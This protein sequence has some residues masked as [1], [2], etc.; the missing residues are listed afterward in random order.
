MKGNNNFQAPASPVINTTL[1]K[2]SK[3][4]TYE[5]AQLERGRLT[6]PIYNQTQSIGFTSFRNKKPTVSAYVPRAE[7]P[8]LQ[9]PLLNVNKGGSVLLD[10]IRSASGNN[11]TNIPEA[12]AVLSVAYGTLYDF[13]QYKIIENM[14]DSQYLTEIDTL[15]EIFKNVQEN[16]KAID[17]SHARI[18]TNQ[19]RA[20]IKPNREVLLLYY[21]LD[22]TNTQS[23]FSKEI[24]RYINMAVAQGNPDGIIK[25]PAGLP[26]TNDFP[27]ANYKDNLF[28]E[29]VVKLKAIKTKN[30]NKPFDL[31]ET[32]F[33]LEKTEFIKELLDFSENLIKDIKTEILNSL[34]SKYNKN[35]DIHIFHITEVEKAIRKLREKHGN[36]KEWREKAVL[37]L[38]LLGIDQMHSEIRDN[39]VISLSGMERGIA[40]A[41]Q[42]INQ[43]NSTF[44]TAKT[45]KNKQQ[46]L[47]AG[48]QLIRGLSFIPSGNGLNYGGTIMR[49]FIQGYLSS[50]AQGKDREFELPTY[51]EM[52]ENENFTSRTTRGGLIVNAPIFRRD[53]QGGRR[54]AEP[55]EYY[56]ASKTIYQKT[57]G[58]AAI[59]F[60]KSFEQ[61]KKY[62][63]TIT[64]IL[65]QKKQRLKK[66]VGNVQSVKHG[67]VKL[68]IQEII[69]IGN[70][71]ESLKELEDVMKSENFGE[72]WGE[73]RIHI[74]NIK[75]VLNELEALK[76]RRD[77]NEKTKETIQKT[78]IATRNLIRAF[79]NINDIRSQISGFVG[80]LTPM[81]GFWGYINWTY[82]DLTYFGL[83]SPLIIVKDFLDRRAEELRELGGINIENLK[84]SFSEGI[85][86]IAEYGDFADS[87]LMGAANKFGA[88]LYEIGLGG[89][90]GY[91]H[92][93]YPEMFY[94]GY[95]QEFTQMGQTFAKDLGLPESFGYM[96]SAYLL[97]SFFNPINL[98]IS[99][100]SFLIPGLGIG[101]KTTQVISTLLKGSMG[102]MKLLGSAGRAGKIGRLAVKLGD[103]VADI[104]LKYKSPILYSIKTGSVTLGLLHKNYSLLSKLYGNIGDVIDSWIVSGGDPTTILG[105]LLFSNDFIGPI[106]HRGLAMSFVPEL[107]T[108]GRFVVQTMQNNRKVGE[109]IKSMGVDQKAV[110]ALDKLIKGELEGVQVY[111]TKTGYVGQIVS[112]DETNPNIVTIRY[113]SGE[114]AL[115]EKRYKGDLVIIDPSLT[116]SVKS[117]P[118]PNAALSLLL[119]LYHRETTTNQDTPSGLVTQIFGNATGEEVLRSLQ[120]L[121][122]IEISQDT[123]R[124]KLTDKAKSIMSLIFDDSLN[125]SVIARTI[126]SVLP[127]TKSTDS[128]NVQNRNARLTRAVLKAWNQLSPELKRAFAV[129][130]KLLTILK[131]MDEINQ[132]GEGLQTI[133]EI[134]QVNQIENA[135]DLQYSV[136]ADGSDGYIFTNKP[137]TTDLSSPDVGIIEVVL[138]TDAAVKPGI[139]D[140]IKDAIESM[141]A[142][143]E[144]IPQAYRKNADGTTS[145]FF[146]GIK[147]YITTD[148]TGQRYKEETTLTDGDMK[149]LA[150]LLSR[151]IDKIKEVYKQMEADPSLH[152]KAVLETIPQIIGGG[153]A[154]KLPDR[155]QQRTPTIKLNYQ[156]QV[157]SL[158]IPAK[159]S[160][161]F[162]TS[163]E[164]PVVETRIRA[165]GVPGHT[166]TIPKELKDYIFNVG[167][168]HATD[169]IVDKI[170]K[171]LADAETTTPERAAGITHLFD[172]RY[173]NIRQFFNNLRIAAQSTDLVH[174]L[175]TFSNRINASYMI[176][177][178]SLQSIGDDEKAIDAMRQILD[179]QNPL[180]E[181]RKIVDKALSEEVHQEVEQILKSETAYKTALESLPLGFKE[182]L[183]RF[184]TIEELF[185]YL[186]DR[187]RDIRRDLGETTP[188][189]R[190]HHHLFG[191][192][193]T[194]IFLQ[195]LRASIPEITDAEIIEAAI[196]VALALPLDILAR[197]GF[198]NI[199]ID[200]RKMTEQSLKGLLEEKL[201]GPKGLKASTPEN[202]KLNT[203]IQ[204]IIQDYAE[205]EMLVWEGNPI[206]LARR[207]M[208]IF[209]LTNRPDLSDKQLL[210]IKDG[211]EA[212]ARLLID[213][214]DSPFD[215]KRDVKLVQLMLLHNKDISE[216][217]TLFSTLKQTSYFTNF[218][219]ASKSPGQRPD[220]IELTIMR[221]LTDPYNSIYLA[222]E[223]THYLHYKWALSYQREK[224]YG[225]HE[226]VS[227]S[228]RKAAKLMNLFTSE[229]TSESEY[230]LRFLSTRYNAN[231]LK[232][233]QPT[234]FDKLMPVTNYGQEMRGIFEERFLGKANLEFIRKINENIEQHGSLYRLFREPYRLAIIYDMN[235]A[236]HT[237]GKAHT[238]TMTTK[239]HL[240]TFMR[241]ID[242]TGGSF[243]EVIDETIT[244]LAHNSEIKFFGEDDEQAFDELAGAAIGASADDAVKTEIELEPHIEM[245]LTLRDLINYSATRLAGTQ[246][247]QSSFDAWK[248]RVIIEAFGRR[249][250]T[251]NKTA[252]QDIQEKIKKNPLVSHAYTN[253]S[254]LGKALMFAITDAATI[255][256]EDPEKNPIEIKT[257]ALVFK[258]PNSLAFEVKLLPKIENED[259]L[260]ETVYARS[261]EQIIRPLARSIENI[262]TLYMRIRK[263]LPERN[264]RLINDTL[265]SLINDDGSISQE[266]VGLLR[267]IVQERIA[268]PIQELRLDL[269][270]NS[271]FLQKVFPIYIVK[272]VTTKDQKTELRVFKLY[273][274]TEID[275]EKSSFIG[276]IVPLIPEN[277]QLADV[278]EE[279]KSLAYQIL[280]GYNRIFNNNTSLPPV[281]PGLRLKRK[282]DGAYLT[283]KEVVVNENGN[284]AAKLVVD[285]EGTENLVIRRTYIK[286][287]PELS[288]E[289]MPKE[290]EGVPADASTETVFSSQIVIS[291]DNQND[292]PIVLF[293][294]FSILEK[295]KHELRTQYGNY[296]GQLANDEDLINIVYATLIQGISE[297]S[298]LYIKEELDTLET[299]RTSVHFGSLD[300]V[301]QK[302]PKAEIS[303]ARMLLLLDL[304]EDAFNKLSESTPRLL[305]KDDMQTAKEQIEKRKQA[306]KIMASLIKK[307]KANFEQ[308][309]NNY[310]QVRVT[311]LMRIAANPHVI[312]KTLDA[313]IDE[314]Y[315][316]VADIKAN[317]GNS[318]FRQRTY[319]EISP[320]LREIARHPF[321]FTPEISLENRL[322]TVEFPEIV[323]LGSLLGPEASDPSVRWI[324]IPTTTARE[325]GIAISDYVLRPF[326][327][328][329]DR[330]SGDWKGDL[331]HEIENR[332]YSILEIERDYLPNLTATPNAILQF[333]M[334]AAQSIIKAIDTQTV[335]DQDFHT[336]TI[337]YLPPTATIRVI[338]AE[339]VRDGIR[340]REPIA[341][342]LYIHDSK[343]NRANKLGKHTL[344]FEKPYLELK[345]QI[346]SSGEVVLID[347]TFWSEYEIPETEQ[348]YHYLKQLGGEMD[349]LLSL[350]AKVE[351]TKKLSQSERNVIRSLWRTKKGSSPN[352]LMAILLALKPSVPLFFIPVEDSFDISSKIITLTPTDQELRLVQEAKREILQAIKQR[353]ATSR[354]IEETETIETRSL[355][356]QLFDT[357]LR[358]D[359]PLE[360]TER[361]ESLKIKEENFERLAFNVFP[362]LNQ[363][364][365]DEIGRIVNEQIR[366]SA[367]TPRSVLM[368]ML[369]GAVQTTY[370]NQLDVLKPILSSSIKDA[371]SESDRVPNTDIDSIADRYATA[372]LHALTNPLIEYSLGSDRL[373]ETVKTLRK[374]I[375]D[376]YYSSTLPQENNGGGAG[377][378]LLT[379]SQ[380]D[381]LS[382]DM[383]N[384]LLK[385]AG[386]IKSRIDEYIESNLQ[387]IEEIYTNF[388]FS[389]IR[390][391]TAVQEQQVDQETIQSQTE[392][393]DNEPLNY[394]ELQSLYKDPELQDVLEQEE[395]TSI[396]DGNV[397]LA[398]KSY[399]SPF[400]HQDR[401]MKDAGNA[402]YFAKTESAP[403]DNVRSNMSVVFGVVGSDD[404]PYKQT[405]DKYEGLIKR[406]ENGVTIFE[407]SK[408]DRM[409]RRYTN[410]PK[411][412]GYGG[413]SQT[414]ANTNQILVDQLEKLINRDDPFSIT[415]L[416]N[417]QPTN[418][419][420][421]APLTLTGVQFKGSVEAL[422]T[423]FVYGQQLVFETDAETRTSIKSKA[424]ADGITRQ[425]ALD[426][427]TVKAPT[428]F[429]SMLPGLVSSVE[430]VMTELKTYKDGDYI[431]APSIL[432]GNKSESQTENGIANGGLGYN[433]YHFLNELNIKINTA[434]SELRKKQA[435]ITSKDIELISHKTFYGI[436]K[437]ALSNEPETKEAKRLKFI[438]EN[439][440][441]AK[442]IKIKVGENRTTEKTVVLTLKD[443]ILLK[444]MAKANQTQIALD[445]SLFDLETG[446]FK[447]APLSP[448]NEDIQNK[449][450][451][452]ISNLD[453]IVILDENTSDETF[454]FLTSILLTI[455]TV[456][457]MTIFSSA[458]A[459]YSQSVSDGL[460][461]TDLTKYKRR[462]QREEE[463]KTKRDAEKLLRFKQEAVIPELSY[464]LAFKHT[465]ADP[466][467][468]NNNATL[469]N[470]NL[471]IPRDEQ[472]E[473]VYD[474][475]TAQ[476]RNHTYT[477]VTGHTNFSFVRPVSKI[478]PTKYEEPN[479]E[480][481][482]RP[483][484]GVHELEYEAQ[485]PIPLLSDAMK[486]AVVISITKL[487]DEKSKQESQTETPITTRASLIQ[488]YATRWGLIIPLQLLEN[489]NKKLLTE[490]E[491]YK[492]TE[493]ILSFS[494]TTLEKPTDA[495]SLL[496]NFNKP[497]SLIQRMSAIA[498]YWMYDIA[499]WVDRFSKRIRRRAF[500]SETI[501]N[502]IGDSEAYYTETAP[503]SQRMGPFLYATA[504]SGVSLLNW[505]AA[506]SRYSIN[507]DFGFAVMAGIIMPSVL[508]FLY[509][510]A[511]FH[512]SGLSKKFIRAANQILRRQKIMGDI[513]KNMTKAL[514]ENAQNPIKVENIKL[515]IYRVINYLSASPL[516]ENFAEMLPVEFTTNTTE[517][518]SSL[519][520]KGDIEI[521]R[522]P[523]SENQDMVSEVNNRVKRIIKNRNTIRNPILNR[524]LSLQE[525][526]EG[527]RNVYDVREQI[528]EDITYILSVAIDE[529]LAEYLGHNRI[530]ETLGETN[531]HIYN[532]LKIFKHLVFTYLMTRAMTNKY[533]VMTGNNI[534]ID[535]TN[536]TNYI[537][538]LVIAKDRD[539]NY[540]IRTDVLI[541]L[542]DTIATQ[543]TIAQQNRSNLEPQTEINEELFETTSV[544]DRRKL[545]GLLAAARFLNGFVQEPAIVTMTLLNMDFS[546]GDNVKAL[547]LSPRDV[548]YGFVRILH[549]R[550]A[551]KNNS[552]YHDREAF[553]A[554]DVALLLNRSTKETA[555]AINRHVEGPVGNLL[556]TLSAQ[557]GFYLGRVSQTPLGA[558]ISF[559]RD[560]L[561]ILSDAPAVIGNNIVNIL[562]LTNPKLFKDQGN[563]KTIFSRIA[564]EAMSAKS[565]ALL[566]LGLPMLGWM[567]DPI[568]FG[569]QNISN[570]VIPLAKT[571]W[572]SY[573]ILPALM[574]YQFRGALAMARALLPNTGLFFS[575]MR[576]AIG[577][578]VI[579]ID[580]G[581]VLKEKAKALVDV[582]KDSSGQVLV[583]LLS[584]IA[585]RHTFNPSQKETE[586]AEEIEDTLPPQQISQAMEVKGATGFYPNK[587]VELI[588]ISRD[589][590][591]KQFLILLGLI[592]PY[593]PDAV[594]KPKSFAAVTVKKK[595]VF[596]YKESEKT[597]TNIEEAI[598]VG[599]TIALKDNRATT[600]EDFLYKLAELI[601]NNNNIE[602]VVSS[603]DNQTIYLNLN[604]NLEE[605][606]IKLR[607]IISLSEILLGGHLIENSQFA[608]FISSFASVEDAIDVYQG[609]VTALK[610]LLDFHLKIIN[611]NLLVNLENKTSTNI[612]V[613]ETPY[614]ISEAEVV[615]QSLEE[616]MR[617]PGSAISEAI[618]R[619]EVL[620]L[621]KKEKEELES[622]KR[623]ETA[624]RA[625]RK[626]YKR[627]SNSIPDDLR[628]EDKIDIIIGRLTGQFN[629][630]N[631]IEDMYGSEI[632]QSMQAQGM[633]G[634]TAG[635]PITNATRTE[636]GDPTLRNIL[637]RTIVG[638]AINDKPTAF[639]ISV[640]PRTNSL[641]VDIDPVKFAEHI[642]VIDELILLLTYN[643]TAQTRYTAVNE[644]N[645]VDDYNNQAIIDLLNTISSNIYDTGIVS[646][647]SPF[648]GV[649][650]YQ[651]DMDLIRF[652]IQTLDDHLM[653]LEY[654]LVN[655][656]LNEFVK[657]KLGTSNQMKG[658]SIYLEKGFSE[659][660]A[661]LVQECAKVNMFPPI[662][663]LLVMLRNMRVILNA[664]NLMVSE[665]EKSIQ[666]AKNT[667]EEIELFTKEFGE[668]I[669]KPTDDLNNYINIRN[670]DMDE[671]RTL[672]LFLM[673]TVNMATQAY[674]LEQGHWIQLSS[675][676][677]AILESQFRT[678]RVIT[679][680]SNFLHL[681]A[682][683]ERVKDEIP[684]PG[685]GVLS[686][687]L[688]ALRKYYEIRDEE[689]NVVESRT[690]V[691]YPYEN[692]LEN[693]LGSVKS[694]SLTDEFLDK[695]RRAMRQDET[696]VAKKEDIRTVEKLSLF[697]KIQQAVQLV[698]NYLELMTIQA[699]RL[700]TIRSKLLSRLVSWVSPAPTFTIVGIFSS[701]RLLLHDSL[702]LYWELM[703]NL[704]HNLIDPIKLRRSDIKPLPKEL[705]GTFTRS[706]VKG[707][708]PIVTTA[709][710]IFA[711]S[712]ATKASGGNFVPTIETANYSISVETNPKNTLEFGNINV[713]NKN[714]NIKYTIDGARF[715]ILLANISDAMLSD[716]HQRDVLNSVAS[717][718][719]KTAAGIINTAASPF[720]SQT[721]IS[722]PLRLYLN[723]TLMDQTKAPPYKAMHGGYTLARLLDDSNPN[724][725][726][727]FWL[728]LMFPITLN[729]LYKLH[730]N[731][732]PVLTKY[733]MSTQSPLFALLNT[734]SNMLGVGTKIKTEQVPIDTSLPIKANVKA[735]GKNIISSGWV[736]D[737]I[738]THKGSQ[739]T[740]GYGMVATGNNFYITKKG[741]KY[742]LIPKTNNIIRE[743][744]KLRIMSDFKGPVTKYI[745][746]Q[747]LRQLEMK[748]YKPAEQYNTFS[749]LTVMGADAKLKI[750]N[751]G[752]EIEVENARG[753]HNNE[754]AK[755][756]LDKIGP[757]NMVTLEDGY[758]IA[759]AV[760]GMTLNIPINVGPINLQVAAQI[761][762]VHDIAQ[763]MQVSPLPAA[764]AVA[765][766]NRT[767]AKY[768]E[769][770]GIFT[771]KEQLVIPLYSFQTTIPSLERTTDALFKI[772]KRL[773]PFAYNKDN[774]PVIEIDMSKD[775]I[776][777]LWDLTPEKKQEV[778]EA[779]GDFYQSIPSTTITLGD[780]IKRKYAI[781]TIKTKILDFQSTSVKT[782][783]EGNKPFDTIVI[784]ELNE[785]NEAINVFLIVQN[786][787]DKVYQRYGDSDY[788]PIDILDR[789]ITNVARDVSLYQQIP[790]LLNGDNLATHFILGSYLE[791]ALQP[792]KHQFDQEITKTY[793]HINEGTQPKDTI[794]G[795]DISD[796]VTTAVLGKD[797]ATSANYNLARLGYTYAVEISNAITQIDRNAKEFYN[798]T[799][800]NQ[801]LLRKYFRYTLKALINECDIQLERLKFYRQQV[802]NARH[803]PDDEKQ[804]LIVINEQATKE[805]KRYRET[806]QYLL[807]NDSKITNINKYLKG[808]ENLVKHSAKA[809]YSDEEITLGMIVLINQYY[810]YNTP[811]KSGVRV[812][813][814]NNKTVIQPFETNIK[815][816]TYI[817]WPAAIIPMLQEPR[818]REL[819]MT[820]QLK[821]IEED[822]IADNARNPIQ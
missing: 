339:I 635:G 477:A 433:L 118:T 516:T 306:Y 771:D 544:S 114:T 447:T 220:M 216:K 689:G 212:Y 564:Q 386:Y 76:S 458:A 495:K 648:Q 591:Y 444:L 778:L 670:E 718:V 605:N 675:K 196:Q 407:K 428:S 412:I 388:E 593:F 681:I 123:G 500:N 13:D 751:Q 35:A 782:T 77:I 168:K 411:Q 245:T 736:T 137:F 641:K 602:V 443:I 210:M 160:K 752:I 409:T 253:G 438:L 550:N 225:L 653:K 53:E 83:S 184:K 816:K 183:N 680:H 700:V 811:E 674:F 519:G 805:L 87:M 276:K 113:G 78:I 305:R 507:N 628:T 385:I 233:T 181:L 54:Y 110:A 669:Y 712:L 686:S 794:P 387:N 292:P 301:R 637:L 488:T 512:R 201:P 439:A 459:S 696:E 410:N 511:R 395:D 102:A 258:R 819:N 737:S 590:P 298:D 490:D 523:L 374:L 381:L 285:K 729:E 494:R 7:I 323:M 152:I 557:A 169:N 197:M 24:R 354:L 213:K 56:E 480:A 146:A 584:E 256:V 95:S 705:R 268:T 732:E 694:I 259:I 568:T 122:L 629:N 541:S 180:I 291:S 419:S 28:V 75:P 656:V 121:G 48:M 713:F 51:E 161:G 32:K 555:N 280:D 655:L 688:L 792:G 724:M 768:T 130:I 361:L 651:A 11:Q 654:H 697:E 208:F 761:F 706:L 672:A 19:L 84:K 755:I 692:F 634:V 93:Y 481:P 592:N 198:D 142:S 625:V 156:K 563:I 358:T 684:G 597:E 36:N 140:M 204:Q 810:Y 321:S 503:A 108:A 346:E 290:I 432:I 533:V 177:M 218:Y 244:G 468:K 61:F 753:N 391:I 746:E 240:K 62:S 284:L 390:N 493:L 254:I 124:I 332:I 581:N 100:L 115:T 714:N 79:N 344:V 370:K 642:G 324:R 515:L 367:H 242:P 234:S 159:P 626:V 58:E 639:N 715:H 26:I 631:L 277:K 266:K 128:K 429:H 743:L 796:Y 151:S 773:V 450:K 187:Y 46:I 509:L 396:T 734:T 475:T 658:K 239:A 217:L 190:F 131:A 742:I 12:T 623:R 297:I 538:S 559:M 397:G 424:F 441:V 566:L 65:T 552:I 224:R 186:A 237:I 749:L 350:T 309:T 598:K 725:N 5:F 733:A 406:E 219:Q 211:V 757:E 286:Y 442:K 164:K 762:R 643:L 398:H 355:I 349:T 741:N 352:S 791:D 296:L 703:T 799:E 316:V 574:Y 178:L 595:K 821:S 801:P 758:I 485:L 133:S 514:Y 333:A 420:S 360:Y 38:S 317:I 479:E 586:I 795:T 363:K 646:G 790:A 614:F 4:F 207:I 112:Q 536:L 30:V 153:E 70:A 2:V 508:G 15:D 17:A 423:L 728:S 380:E 798:K 384:D 261:I 621:N 389:T 295:W 404:S 99:V 47:M 707:L 101:L 760:N 606:E 174:S 170:L 652:N 335:D 695:V 802:E 567:Y 49:N 719:G 451:T 561:A 52:L 414:I 726:Y 466:Y 549:L 464:A 569:P 189:K 243:D 29:V 426:E 40:L 27:L 67:V 394:E 300:E 383:A 14:M 154:T 521:T 701:L 524:V 136:S 103:T 251:V 364:T 92:V 319:D 575:A 175:K 139:I 200:K 135:L 34:G 520:Y 491:D 572:M 228:F 314:I 478:D 578:S 573:T 449:F 89:K 264:W 618:E 580:L 562:T 162:F 202:A 554:I 766:I 80:T 357:L 141:D 661:W 627:Y 663:N 193:Y 721:G 813:T 611:P 418:D 471:L 617:K 230:Y 784:I 413:V 764:I 57:L 134:K 293:D 3:T 221:G 542:F 365:L 690:K 558:I 465:S 756:L 336:K 252:L 610:N 545:T 738:V 341:I 63:G 677:P 638:S 263:R 535:L 463:P 308:Q 192:Y 248:P 271:V 6:H 683:Y 421:R 274:K 587:M 473:V 727:N 699:P 66:E 608:E 787:K 624:L 582:L 436:L 546:A 105:T 8:N 571:T 42:F 633:L 474:Y 44:K 279:T 622:R 191:I 82:P 399:P 287:K 359:E 147:H 717:F 788:D 601:E 431:R 226:T 499:F 534:D 288:F 85:F 72:R 678:E 470:G 710:A 23:K 232:R 776:G 249:Q 393:I 604:D 453:K 497:I 326:D 767:A 60:Y 155:T 33:L 808:I 427:I 504:V 353:I 455:T 337:L 373:R 150:V 402:I 328:P 203:A 735:E 342:Q 96:A 310:T 382:E 179:S 405:E 609:V 127:E 372:L 416:P 775:V 809:T 526:E 501:L 815:I 772:A 754:V 171:Q 262:N 9:L 143:L 780:N 682:H 215:K 596:I 88:Y 104:G 246:H 330:L 650:M 20:S 730:D 109:L 74:M 496:I 238:T 662:L 454:E 505:L 434:I 676:T 789:I 745:S 577:R 619:Q 281:H 469:I 797:K 270:G 679:L 329:K 531:K 320:R 492:S 45:L 302:P 322:R 327:I 21:G 369:D 107:A 644:T 665:I 765:G 149:N 820:N 818:T 607:E 403:D 111:D 698:G 222:E 750:I 548:F 704:I 457:S 440:T 119:S 708:L 489:I 785:N 278:T 282:R 673:S 126:E 236:A 483:K 205:L 647:S 400:K 37:A 401:R 166:K 522:K 145:L 668:A 430:K 723:Q 55:I 806:L 487:L 116:E 294:E 461:L 774:L 50:L 540:K 482:T 408:I 257:D 165:A 195:S 71:L 664:R 425:Y 25:G 716:T 283:V 371:I 645:T 660:M 666:R 769:S 194:I 345:E 334:A 64:N 255:T 759:S 125:E 770:T 620:S 687:E 73:I 325:H 615:K 585:S 537:L 472:N 235:I 16:K 532:G 214:Y 530:L 206:K 312:N 803:I 173:E 510:F 804:N 525:I 722:Y 452:L 377:V 90:V 231:L 763:S 172:L 98:G 822:K 777:T 556:S 227:P 91:Y 304:L 417:A 250:K 132:I 1:D 31:P 158:G 814:K 560:W 185:V 616:Y 269:H 529:A 199:L 612:Y 565:A 543:S 594:L 209:D 800:I 649:P 506:I 275:V 86:D 781:G 476:E 636:Y 528:Y 22:T 462:N 711:L 69:K 392:E 588:R 600:P 576:N 659:F 94:P 167:L 267:K 484:P 603:G 437:E 273:L 570:L 553:H 182:D 148:A 812:V 502:D 445:Q 657:Q 351:K 640:D 518:A 347:D 188:S 779:L 415:I 632:N 39:A 435:T 460:L 422:Y 241:Q 748:T 289:W 376:A 18:D 247:V 691:D 272:K 720:Q 539:K 667:N 338:S 467:I 43:A 313:S 448:Q 498:S 456:P 379:N 375:T 793:V 176:K 517:A 740:Y 786:T 163:Q 265:A 10:L 613:G 739:L 378:I 117:L 589:D 513:V 702:K 362:L 744:T 783:L 366:Y 59:D 356:L 817:N 348:I 157:T 527:K 599:I 630:M 807:S 331:I 307:E 97:S 106:R 685:F 579:N 693:I 229:L 303:R 41:K 315:S 446:Y 260:R 318:T 138:S 129:R 311:S 144:I 299:A 547:D 747:A 551:I 81:Q 120:T 486:L 223:A 731:M 709:L 68:H 340:K 583:V 368:T 671:T 343:V